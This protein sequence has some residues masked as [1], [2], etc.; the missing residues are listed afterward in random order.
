MKFDNRLPRLSSDPFSFVV[1]IIDHDVVAHLVGGGVEDPAGVHARQ[2]ID[3]ALPIVIAA[4]HE[5][6]D[7]DA[8]L[9]AA[10]HFLQSLVHDAAADSVVE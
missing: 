6:V 9:G 7:L 2:L 4:Q 5:R 1:E 8:A 3:E 10:F